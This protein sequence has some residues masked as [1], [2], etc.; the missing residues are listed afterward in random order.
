F[1]R[2]EF[3]PG[4]STEQ[5]GNVFGNMLADPV[6]LVFW[7]LLEVALCFIILSAG[8]QSGLEKVT[9]IMMGALLILIF[10]LGLHSLVL[11]G[12]IEVL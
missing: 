11:P 7:M 2:G 10:V 6:E 9:K 12:G 1:I 5:I 3:T 8:I 4:M